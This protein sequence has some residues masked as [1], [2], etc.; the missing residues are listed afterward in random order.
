[1]KEKLIEPE[2]TPFNRGHPKEMERILNIM[3]EGVSHVNKTKENRNVFYE[4]NDKYILEKFE[5][6][7]ISLKKLIQQ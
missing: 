2:Q 3:I 7:A 1:M 6:T 4:L 5:L